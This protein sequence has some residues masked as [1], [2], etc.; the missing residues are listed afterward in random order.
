MTNLAAVFLRFNQLTNLTLP[1][2]LTNL[3]QI[4]VLSNQLSTLT[5]PPDMTRLVTLVLEGNPLTTLILSESL[6]ATN[7]AGT[8]ASLQNQGVS[9]F[10]YPLAVQLLQPRSLSG[11]FQ[12]GITGP[13][14][15][16]AVLGTTDFV[17]WT[18]VGVTT[19][20]VGSISFDD[21]TISLSSQKFYRA[22]LQSPL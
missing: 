21:V 13:P 18:E 15:V 10:T 19:N 9:V 3:V 12:F 2:G 7:L 16:Y 17:V 1:T 4:D 14:G 20:K 5:L 11:A 8:V 6:A 22:Q